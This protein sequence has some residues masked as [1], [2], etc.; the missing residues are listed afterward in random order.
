[1][2]HD[3]LETILSGRLQGRRKLLERLG[4]EARDPIEELVSSALEFESASAPSLQRFLD[5]FARGDVEVVRDPSAPMDAVR[6]MTVHGSKGLQAPLVVL[7]D[8]CGDPDRRG[9]GVSGSFASVELDR[10]IGPVPTF[11]PRKDELPE[12][13][14]AQ[15]QEQDRR[16]R[17]EHWRLLY[18]ALT[19]AEERLFI[20]GALGAADANG[21]AE[22]SWYRAVERSLDALGCDWEEDARWA[23]ARR[24]GDATVPARS[25]VAEAPARPGSIPD[26]AAR[27]AP[28]EPRPPRPLA[29]S[30]LGE[31]DVRDPPPGPAMRA[32]AERGKLLHQLFERMPA[33]PPDRRAALADSWLARA[34][35]VSDETLRLALVAD[36]A[37]I[38]GNADFS[39]LF[40]PDALA[41]APIAAV[42]ADGSVITGTV[43]RLLVTEERVRLVDF[44]TGR[45][46]PESLGDVPVA[47]L[48]QMAAYVAAL[49]VVFPG[50]A[51]DAALLYTAGP[52]LHP[53][54]RDLLEEHWPRPGS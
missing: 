47:H 17:Q 20:G 50:R 54:P 33:A 34:A 25:P 43:D 2:P 30:A 40:S 19:R 16:D 39:E 26:W 22:S 23:K 42:T 14:K 8:A 10:E 7:A 15:L 28:H 21:P 53:L 46:A 31:D 49:E 3:F 5:W 41:E 12:P 38:V 36:A 29:P 52:V 35:G 32:A 18:V 11:R 9:G 45:K 44:K 13:F 37:A 27:P 24:L 6:V 48:R 1:T 51:I 4:R